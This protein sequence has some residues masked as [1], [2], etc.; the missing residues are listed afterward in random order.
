MFRS[1]FRVCCVLLF[2]RGRCFCCVLCVACCCF[3]VDVVVRCE[4]RVAY[5]LLVDGRCC[6]W[7]L[8]LAVG[9]VVSC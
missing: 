2:N 5:C 9:V 4:L 7:R 8:L 6:C 1:W 3:L